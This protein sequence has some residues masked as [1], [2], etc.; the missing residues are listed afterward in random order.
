MTEPSFSARDIATFLRDSG[1]I[2]AGTAHRLEMRII[3]YGE[4]RAGDGRREGIQACARRAAAAAAGIKGASHREA[5]VKVLRAVERLLP[6]A[7][8]ARREAYSRG[9]NDGVET[10]RKRQQQK[11]DIR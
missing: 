9:F 2:D 11:P 5:G 1:M 7:N 4:S 10:Q 8:D 6:S 3:A